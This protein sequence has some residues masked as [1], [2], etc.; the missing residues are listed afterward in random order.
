MRIRGA[1]GSRINRSIRSRRGR[2]C[3]SGNTSAF[4]VAWGYSLKYDGL[5][6]RQKIHGEAL[7]RLIRK[8]SICN[9]LIM[10]FGI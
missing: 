2:H 9:Y 3:L 1:Q 8:D 7:M 10:S 6:E 4:L 5:G